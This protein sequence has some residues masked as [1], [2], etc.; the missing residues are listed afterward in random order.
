MRAKSLYKAI[1][2]IFIWLGNTVKWRP[3]ETKHGRFRG[4][5]STA[6]NETIAGQGTMGGLRFLNLFHQT[7]F[8]VRSLPAELQ[9]GHC[10][11][12]VSIQTLPWKWLRITSIRWNGRFTFRVFHRWYLRVI[13]LIQNKKTPGWHPR[14]LRVKNEKSMAGPVDAEL[15]HY[16]ARAV[17]VAAITGLHFPIY[18]SPRSSQPINLM[19]HDSPRNRSSCTN[20]R[21]CSTQLILLGKQ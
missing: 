5:R 15:N 18:L 19:Q 17:V 6:K 20:E 4:N 11:T 2:A 3:D 13:S 9:T 8:M 7:S 21:R 14:F 16:S 1:T 12:M 10:S